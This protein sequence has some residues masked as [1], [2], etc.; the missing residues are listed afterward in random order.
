VDTREPEFGRDNVV[1]R[2]CPSEMISLC[3]KRVLIGITLG[4]VQYCDVLLQ[5]FGRWF[6]WA[7]ELPC[8]NSCKPC[9]QRCML[10]AKVAVV[11]SVG[12]CV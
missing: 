1:A 6:W 3:R 10:R 7:D 9:G 5:A 2:C 12:R 4:R 8:N 11:G